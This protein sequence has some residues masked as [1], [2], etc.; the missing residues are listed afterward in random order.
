MRTVVGRK[1][2]QPILLERRVP[3]QA[4]AH[5]T[6]EAIFEAT[7]RIIERDGVAAL[8]TNVIAE[9]AGLSIGTLYEYFPNKEAVLIAMARRR[10]AQDERVV[11][12]A[13]YDAIDDPAAPLIRIAIRTLVALQRERPKVRRAIMAVHLASGL[14]SE[15]AKPVQEI[16]QLLWERSA[17]IPFPLSRASL[18]V[19]TRAV[20]GVIR[21]AFEER[22]QLPGTRE[23]EDELVRMVEGYLAQL[24]P[25]SG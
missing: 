4:R 18:F 16:A 20:I 15:H 13:L 5:A 19:L 6:I 12:Q 24:R 11:R 17:S 7:A 8:N 25:L 22:S 2:T 14:S 23:L 21:A 10:L 3:T 1:K 9:R